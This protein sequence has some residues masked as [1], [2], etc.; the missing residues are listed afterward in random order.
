MKGTVKI[1]YWDT[2]QAGARPPLLGEIKGT[3][4]IRLYKPKKKQGNSD[5]K[6]VVV[7]YNYERKAK[8]MKKFADT[9]MPNFIEKVDGPKDMSAFEEKAKRHG[10]PMALVFTS[11]PNTS[12]LTKYLSTEFRRRLLLTEIKPTKP[13]KEII[14]KYGV[15]DFPALVIVPPNDEK[16]IGPIL[17]D[18]DGFTRHRLHSFLSKHALKDKVLPKKKEAPK[19]EQN[20][21]ANKKGANQEEKIHAKKKKEK[22]EL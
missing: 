1:A 6:K 7:D 22:V 3:P 21:D 15:T 16:G 14:E 19:E 9:Q 18:G 10:L 5:R 17:Y 12:P 13:N 4:T 20:D 8:D 2:E 11:K